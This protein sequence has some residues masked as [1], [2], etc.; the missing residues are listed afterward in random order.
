MSALLLATVLTFRDV[1]TRVEQAHATPQHAIKP[2]GPR[3]P[4]LRAEMT[5]SNNGT[6]F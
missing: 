2:A 4:P 3:L 1:L 6:L 5:L